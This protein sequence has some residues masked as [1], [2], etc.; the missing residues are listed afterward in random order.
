MPLTTEPSYSAQSKATE[1][2]SDFCV[3][4]WVIQEKSNFLG[5]S[6]PAEMLV[7]TMR[8]LC[9]HMIKGLLVC[10]EKALSHATSS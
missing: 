8:V 9:G 5:F 7:L 6:F 3:E 2:D 10:A 1:R 4:N